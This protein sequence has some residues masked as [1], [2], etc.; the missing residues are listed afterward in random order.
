ME[1]LHLHLYLDSEKL[2]LDLDLQILDLDLGLKK[3]ELDVDSEKLDLYLDLEKNYQ[4]NRCKYHQAKTGKL[5]CQGLPNFKQ[6][7][8]FFVCSALFV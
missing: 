3:L 7:I 6:H 1:K 8:S 5:D 2:N 4:D